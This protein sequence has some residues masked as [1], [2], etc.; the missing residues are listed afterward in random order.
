MGMKKGGLGG[1]CR[2][3]TGAET[4]SPEKEPQLGPTAVDGSAVT[5]QSPAV[6]LQQRGGG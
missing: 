1:C 6:C 5:G 3:V 4:V 2:L